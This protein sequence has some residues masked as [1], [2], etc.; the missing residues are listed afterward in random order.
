MDRSELWSR[1]AWW[2]ALLCV[3]A[4]AGFLVLVF[5]QALVWALEAAR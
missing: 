3:V 4:W 1:T 2:A 5:V